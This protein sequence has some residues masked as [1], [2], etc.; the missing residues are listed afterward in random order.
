MEHR[1]CGFHHLPAGISEVMFVRG[2]EPKSRQ[3]KAR[4]LKQP[5][6]LSAFP[7]QVGLVIA[8]V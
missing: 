1:R 4:E 3:R 7:P 6:Q 8:L 5:V 2:N